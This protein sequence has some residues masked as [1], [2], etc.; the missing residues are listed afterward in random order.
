MAALTLAEEIIADIELVRLP[1]P[2]I[3]KKASRLARLMDD[4]D[5]IDWLFQELTGY[6]QNGDGTLTSK[7]YKAA[8]RSNR[9]SGKDPKSGVLSF[10]GE[11][12]DKIYATADTSRIRLQT[13]KINT[14][15]ERA[16]L[17]RRVID[18]QEIIGR[19]T[20][21]VHAYVAERAIELRFGAAT[22]DAFM[23]IRG[24]VDKHIA[25]LTPSAAAKFAV[26][27]DNAS[28]GNPESWANAA[29][30][31]R[32]LLKSI[33]DELRPP[34]GAVQGR[35]MTDAKYIN[36]LID[37]I[38]N[39]PTKEVTLKDVIT[40]DLEDFG[41][42]IDAFDDAGHK[43]AHSTVTKYEASRFITGAYLLV[44][45]ILHLWKEAKGAAPIPING[46]TY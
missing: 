36:R 1:A 9:L 6:D 31:C 18:Y 24:E 22:E 30:A 3:V 37:W 8:L 25:Q 44:G 12:V 5:A 19:I 38:V 2:K 4:T 14:S 35:P 17:N 42:R 23:T 7:G 13:E 32:R 27:F 33:A 15:K 16:D 40:A 10:W 11:T 41:K 34:G 29:S 21:S 45:D 20:G 28:S 46:K 39:Q 26:A 43:G